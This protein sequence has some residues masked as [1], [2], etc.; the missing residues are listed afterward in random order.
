[1]FGR[2]GMNGQQ[3]VFEPAAEEKVGVLHHLVDDVV[4][5]GN[6]IA[7]MAGTKE[8]FGSQVLQTAH[9]PVRLVP[10]KQVV[11]D[12]KIEHCLGRNMWRASS[13]RK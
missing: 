1:M 2:V 10:E 5:P 13:Q 7:A 12:V 6:P 9:A 11:F 8:Q 3:P 4:P